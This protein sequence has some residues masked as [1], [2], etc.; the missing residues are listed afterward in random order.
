VV[1]VDFPVYLHVSLLVQVVKDDGVSALVSFP[2]GVVHDSKC[3]NHGPLGGLSPLD[4][5][6]R[7]MFHSFWFG[8]IRRRGM[9]FPFCIP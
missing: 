3:W 5:R 2:V 4:D 9:G 1:R 8:V 6:L 7:M